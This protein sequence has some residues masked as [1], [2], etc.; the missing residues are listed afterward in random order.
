M[1]SP[2]SCRP[3]DCISPNTNK[4]YFMQA[5]QEILCSIVASL[6]ANRDIVFLPEVTK[7]FGF[8]TNAY[9]AAGFVDAEKLLGFFKVTNLT[10][11][12]I[13]GSFDNVNPAFTVQAGQTVI[14]QFAQDGGQLTVTNDVYLKYGSAVPSLGSVLLEGYYSA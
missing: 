12:E 5:V 1:A 14:Y 4:Q 10:D 8:F 7:A 3:C 9:Q 13:I 6:P 2:S 11:G